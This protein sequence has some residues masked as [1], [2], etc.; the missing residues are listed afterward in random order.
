MIN[1]DKIESQ[2]GLPCPILFSIAKQYENT[3]NALPTIKLKKVDGDMEEALLKIGTASLKE[4]KFHYAM[5]ASFMTNNTIIAWHNFE[6]KHASPIA[7]NLVH[8]SI[9]NA[10]ASDE[11]SISVTNEPL[12]IQP[13]EEL[14]DRGLIMQADSTFEFL[15]PFI[16]Y[17][18]MSILSAKYT[19][20]YIE[21]SRWH[22]TE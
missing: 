17:I 6:M 22:S 12:S 4:Y 2:R 3:V 15:F 16:V 8:T 1:I 20:F 11:Y 18:I 14:Y 9:I 7:L 21:V 10:F 19:S 5:G 13:E